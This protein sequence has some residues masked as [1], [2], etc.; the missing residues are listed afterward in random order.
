LPARLA[1]QQLAAMLAPQEVPQ[2]V[3]GV[4]AE[5]GDD[6]HQLDIH[7]FAERKKPGKNQNGFTFEKR[8]EKE[9]EVAEILKKLLEHC[10]DAGEMNAQP[11]PSTTFGKVSKCVS[12]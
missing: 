11:T 3:T 7:V 1:R 9:G 5:E 4:A 6:H 8:A 12:T 10:L 2:L